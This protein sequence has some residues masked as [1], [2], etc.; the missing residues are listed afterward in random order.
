M[1]EIDPICTSEESLENLEENGKL[2]NNLFDQKSKEFHWTGHP[3]VDAGL[4]AIIIFSR[5]EKPQ[6][7]TKKDITLAIKF[8]SELYS[9]EEWVK[10]FHGK[11]FPNSG[12]LISNPSPYLKKERTPENLTRNLQE[13]YK[14]IPP[15]IENNSDKSHCAIC[16]RRELYN[17]D[18]G[19]YR[20]VFPLLGTGGMLNFFPSGNKKGLDICAHCLFLTQFM[21]LSSYNLPNVLLIHSTPYEKMLELL[22]EPIQ[23][24]IEN[25]LFSNGRDF[26]KPE[27]FLFKK[28]IEITRKTEG[29]NNFWKHT[30]ITLY[31][32]INGNRSGSQNMKITQIP[33]STLKFIAFAGEIDYNGWKTLINK[34]WIIK[35]AKKNKLSY[36]ELEKGYSNGIYDKILNEDLII[37][38]FY[39]SR[40]KRANTKWRLLEFYCLE[41]L[42]VDKETLEF[43]KEVGDRVVGT[44][45]KFESTKEVIKMIADLENAERLYVF[46][47]FFVRLEKKRQKLGI[48]E[49]LISF[50]DFAKILTF[51]GE[52]IDLSWR[53]VRDLLLFRIYEKLHDE[54]MGTISV[55]IDEEE[56]LFGGEIE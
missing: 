53:S 46:E 24:A 55:N 8:A 25:K 1:S 5:K 31:Y 28:I 41:V 21:P 9:K 17:G 23:Y 3:F 43:I 26:K 30:S 10:Y 35:E 51:Y 13:V 56:T 18:F 20:Q 27:N 15:I 39:D 12:L 6:E 50:D 52:N 49:A 45:D 22:K 47:R 36:K 14:S 11:L 2:E 33:T 29:G 32:F 48:P 37:S 42:N 4:A 7:L 16:G 19:I 40:E 38:Y 34:G 44:F 54:L